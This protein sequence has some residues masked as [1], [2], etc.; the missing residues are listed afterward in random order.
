MSKGSRCAWAWFPPSVSARE[1][2]SPWVS[3]D[4][5]VVIWRHCQP[6]EVVA[7]L[8]VPNRAIKPLDGAKTTGFSGYIGIQRCLG[9]SRE[10][11]TL[12]PVPQTVMAKENP[13]R[14]STYGSGD[15]RIQ[16]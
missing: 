1:A 14:V 11:T 15:S 6:T 12:F 4:A 5:H 8:S 3:F 7:A 2:V 10:A 9:L 16:R 13:T